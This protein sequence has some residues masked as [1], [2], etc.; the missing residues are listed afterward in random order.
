MKKKVLICCAIAMLT[1]LTNITAQT[2]DVG[3]LPGKANVSPS[4]AFTYA[5]PIDLPSSDWTIPHN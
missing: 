4:G 5:I 2:Y 1:Q 3:S